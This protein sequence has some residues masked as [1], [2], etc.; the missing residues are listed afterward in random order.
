M[1]TLNFFFSFRTKNE[2]NKLLTFNFVG[3]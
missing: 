1:G 3:I 2:N